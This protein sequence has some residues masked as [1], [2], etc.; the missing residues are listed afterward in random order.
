[1]Y[2]VLFAG[3]LIT[4]RLG[5]FQVFSFL[6]VNLY[7]VCCGTVTALLQPCNTIRFCQG[8]AK[9]LAAK[10]IEPDA[11]SGHHAEA[12]AFPARVRMNRHLES[13]R[14]SFPLPG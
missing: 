2:R 14:W 12:A 6:F 5:P 13:R 10:S 4:K 8:P 1:M 11:G 9:R 3:R 7:P